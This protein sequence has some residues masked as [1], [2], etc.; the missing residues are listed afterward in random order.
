MHDQVTEEENMNLQDHE[1][2][3]FPPHLNLLNNI[4]HNLHSHVTRPHSYSLTHP[5]APPATSGKLQ[6]MIENLLILIPHRHSP[7][8]KC[9]PGY[10]TFTMVVAASVNTCFNEIADILVLR[11]VERLSCRFFTG[12]GVG[13]VLAQG[14]RERRISGGMVIARRKDLGVLKL[15]DL[16]CVV[17]EGGMGMGMEIRR[18]E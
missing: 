1:D 12:F 9:A 10:A 2:I 13:L 8:K 11:A 7:N 14:V 17:G 5:T 3:Y 6:S 4:C 16:V 15:L 18:K